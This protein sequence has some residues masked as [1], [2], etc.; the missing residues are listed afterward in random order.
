MHIYI[1]SPYKEVKNLDKKKFLQERLL[2]LFQRL[3]N[4]NLLKNNQIKIIGVDGENY[5]PEL[6]N[7]LSDN[8]RKYYLRFLT[9][10]KGG[11][12]SHIKILQDIKDNDIKENVLIIEDD[13]LIHYNI[14]NLIPETFPEDY[15]VLTLHCNNHNNYLLQNIH[16]A[17]NIKKITNYDL[18]SPFEVHTYFVNGCN[19][20]KILDALLPLE[21]QIDPSLISN[22]KLNNYIFNPA[23]EL[24]A[25]ESIFDN[26]W[27]IDSYT[28]VINNYSKHFFLEFVNLKENFQNIDQ[29]FI[30]EFLCHCTMLHGIDV[31][32]S[33]SFYIYEKDTDTEVKGIKFEHNYDM[34][35]LDQEYQKLYCKIQNSELLTNGME[36]KF[37][38]RYTQGSVKECQQ[39][40]E[41]LRYFKYSLTSD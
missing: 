20:S 13:A 7:Y 4:A 23:L 1:V 2:R 29:N 27:H 31:K 37:V 21:W 15:D 5:D 10:T 35:I 12:L 8:W 30:F 33:Y 6:D 3:D 26:S 11:A 40:T 22:P 32:S 17:E 38:I 19:I 24:S 34:S 9:G 18:P 28:R 14:L 41:K 25:Q 16:F 36:Y 39:I